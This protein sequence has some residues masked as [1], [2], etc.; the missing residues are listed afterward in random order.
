M[1]LTYQGKKPTIGESVFIAEGA[2]VIADVTLG[3]NVSIWFNA[4]VRGDVNYIKIGKN[5]NIQDNSVL[6][7]TTATAPLNIGKNVTVGHNVILHGCTIEDN[8]LIGSGAIIWDGAVIGEG[9][10]VGAGAIVLAGF[11]APP[12]SL[13]L[14]SPASIKKQVSD[15]QYEMVKASAE[16][17]VHYAKN[18]MNK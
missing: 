9:S 3:D 7:V 11:K 4:I 5:T 1:I 13:I 8:C 10:I 16:H 18:Y 2:K 17:Y 15:E 6:H 14:G 12:R